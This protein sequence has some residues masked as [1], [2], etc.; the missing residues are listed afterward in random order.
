MKFTYAK[1]TLERRE[2]LSQITAYDC[3]NVSRVYDDCVIR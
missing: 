2:A 3:N 1:P